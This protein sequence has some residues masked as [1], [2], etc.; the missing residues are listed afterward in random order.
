ML[1]VMGMDLCTYDEQTAEVGA[2]AS[3]DVILCT[4]LGQN[5]LRYF[6][7]PEIAVYTGASGQIC[8]ILTAYREGRLQSATEASSCPGRDG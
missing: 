6:L 3:T 8:D 5:A 1:K 7:G 4:N 2:D